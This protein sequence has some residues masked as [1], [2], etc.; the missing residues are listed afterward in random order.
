V[1]V[2]RL[3]ALAALFAVE[4]GV[5]TIWLDGPRLARGGALASLFRDWGPIIL[6]EAVVFATV[7]LTFACLRFQSALAAVSERMETTGIQSGLLFAHALALAVFGA[8][9]I[10]LYRTGASIQQDWLA[11]GWFAAG[12]GAIAFG[13]SAFVRPVFW[14]QIFQATGSLWILALSAASAVALSGPLMTLLW[15]PATAL[16][17]ALA[18]VLLRPFGVFYA[19]PNALSIGNAKFNVVLSSGCSGL[20]GVGLILAFTTVWLVLFRREC[21]FPQALL[22]LPLGTVIIYLLNSVRVASLVL[23]GNAGFESIAAGGFHSQA[24]WIAFNFV[25]LGICLAAR[26]VRWISMAKTDRGTAAAA[27]SESANPVA[28]WILPFVLILAAGMAARAASATFEWLYPLRFLAAAAAVWFFRRQY[29]ALDWHVDWTGATAGVLVFALWIGLDHS[30]AG[31]APPELASA[32]PSLAFGWIAVRA[33]A[34]VITV[35]IAEELAFRG[36]LL[37]RF[38]AADFQA[39]SFR[40]F[41]WLALI[42]SS[43]IFGALHGSRWMAGSLAGAIYALTVLRRGWLGNAVVAHATTNALIALDVLVFHHWDLW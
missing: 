28:V 21:R 7:F 4:L 18:Q 29:C 37:R 9:S 38:I 39:V 6:R 40:Q 16:T 11:V 41:S 14:R 25:A 19:D 33:L 30:V 8:F 10:G 32:A 43:V 20:E 3:L 34:A 24:G 17:L 31:P 23:V 22:L 35:P 15:R 36:F 1:L 2:R 5:I 12:F 13:A 26:E 42:A 27:A